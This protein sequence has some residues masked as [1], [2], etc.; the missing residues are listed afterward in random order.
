MIDPAVTAA[1]TRTVGESLPDAVA[2]LTGLVAIPSVS[3]PAFDPSQV[4]RSAEAISALA[5]ASGVFDE[6]AVH[7]AM[8]PGT[9][10]HG[11]PAI[12]ATRAARPGQRR[13][14]L[15]AHHDVQPVGDESL[16]ATPPFEATERD[17]RRCVRCSATT[18]AWASPCSLK[19]RRST[20]PGPSRSSSPITATPS[21]RT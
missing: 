15:Y 7:S 18:S 5:T 19:V 17:G 12:L 3:W 10:E 1:L 9:S 16:W 4:V 6:V 2:E 8:I 11:Q 13:V 14:L 20:V 21:R